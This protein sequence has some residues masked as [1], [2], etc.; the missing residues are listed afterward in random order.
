M[1]TL[2]LTATPQSVALPVGQ[3]LMIIENLGDDT[4]YY[5]TTSNV[6]SQTYDGE[7]AV[8]Q[9][10]E[11]FSGPE[12]FVT[13]SVSQISVTYVSQPITQQS[14]VTASW[15][16]N[17][18]TTDLPWFDITD[19]GAAGDGSTDDT[20]A[21]AA[22][23]AQT[24]VKSW[25]G[26]IIVMPPGFNSLV[27]GGV[28]LDNLKDI[29]ILGQ[30]G[31]EGGARIFTTRSDGGACVSAKSSQS[32]SLIGLEVYHNGPSGTAAAVV[33]VSGTTGSPS[34]FFHTERCLL[35]ANATS[36]M[37]IDVLRLPN[38]ISVK[39]AHTEMSGGRY[40][41]QGRGTV[42]DF[43]NAICVDT[44]YFGTAD[45][46]A[47]H[48]LGQGSHI[49]GSTVFEPLRSGAPGGILQDSTVPVSGLKMDV[50]W[51]GDNT[52]GGTWCVLNGAGIAI[53]GGT[54]NSGTTSGTTAIQFNAA[55]DGVQIAG[56]LFRGWNLGIDK[57]SQTVTN[58]GIGPNSYN[59]VTTHHNFTAAGTLYVES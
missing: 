39:L 21:W 26:G 6:S 8:G 55:S 51:V 19:F 59:G 53:Q 20:N 38:N 2:N 37:L 31:Q 29:T 34:N 27:S 42:S 14:L 56:N 43:L 50:P 57:N 22:A 3:Q 32:I 5:R 28:V 4:V 9:S 25:K 48:N 36:G 46:C 7:L 35:V 52:I 33:D 12:W 23:I 1:T 24:Q 49:M 47:I 44:C 30:G 13:P 11:F 16:T 15:R 10:T 40:Q 45:L 41:L 58:V 17:A 54:I 18:T